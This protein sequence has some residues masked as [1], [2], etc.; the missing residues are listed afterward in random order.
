MKL[1]DAIAAGF[2]DPTTKLRKDG[3]TGRLAFV[4]ETE[5]EVLTCLNEVSSLGQL[6]DRFQHDFQT[7][8]NSKNLDLNEFE[9]G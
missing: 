8:K 3:A 9:V 4:D 5:G 6:L 1:E 2:V 7:L